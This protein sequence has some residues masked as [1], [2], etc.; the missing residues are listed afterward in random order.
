MRSNLFRLIVPMSVLAAC[1]GGGNHPDP[2]VIPGGGVGD[3]AIDGEVNVYVIDA[4]TDAPVTT[5][6]VGVADIEA[7]VDDTGLV[8][9]EDVKGPQTVVVKATGYRSAVWAGVNGANITIP[10]TKLQTGTVPQ[11]TLSGSITGYESVTPTAGVKAALLMYTQTDDLGDPANEL[12]TPNNANVCFGNTCAW[13]LVSR[14]GSVHVMAAIVQVTDPNNTP[15]DSSDDVFEILGWASRAVTVEDG[16]NQSGIALDMI[17][18]GDLDNVTVDLGQPPAGLPE[19]GTIVGIEMG[20]DEVAQIPVSF[21]STDGPALL[22]KL[23]AFP[24]ST[25][26]LTAIAQTASA[27]AGAQSIVLHR[28]QTATTLDAGTWLVPPTGV[29]ATRTSASWNV[30]SGALLHQVSY[31]NADGDTILDMTAFD[32]TVTTLNVPTL[33]AL[34]TSEALTARVAGLAAT[35]DVTNFS[36]DTDEDTITGLASQPINIQ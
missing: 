32:S 26:R 35:L 23:S 17:Q 29:T 6:T 27:D 11:A 22:P 3:G 19:L 30:V 25:Y 31:D 16:V 33:V 21:L 4:D 28:D 24:G 5:A 8:I 18:T 10:L 7:A 20:D 34:P 2:H 1:G 9:V 36:L 12:T 13:S 15:A 14:A